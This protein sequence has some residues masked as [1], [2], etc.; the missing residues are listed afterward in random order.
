MQ[1]QVVKKL[2]NEVLAMR[3]DIDTLQRLQQ[4]NQP[5]RCQLVSQQSM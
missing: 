2:R 1:Y 3:G 5:E 4:E